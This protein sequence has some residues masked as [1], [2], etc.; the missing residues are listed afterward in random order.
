MAGR[1]L[2]MSLDARMRAVAR[3]EIAATPRQTAPDVSGLEKQIADLHEELHAVATKVAALEQQAEPLAASPDQPAPGA[4][5]R[6]SRP[7][8][9]AA[10]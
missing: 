2:V 1:I 9:A 4:V 5:P 3:Q 10:E 8:K 7:R 6:A